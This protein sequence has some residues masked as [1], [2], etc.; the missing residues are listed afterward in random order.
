MA[1][2]SVVG[3]LAEQ[4]REQPLSEPYDKPLCSRVRGYGEVFEIMS[5]ERLR[6]RLLRKRYAPD[7]ILLLAPRRYYLKEII[8]SREVLEGG[9]VDR[10]PW[11][12]NPKPNGSEPHKDGIRLA[13]A[14]FRVLM[15]FEKL[16]RAHMVYVLLR[17]K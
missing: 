7:S 8:G 14:I 12:S 2:L 1:E 4:P 17:D 6:K 16:N 3:T 15:L 13:K 11:A 9:F 10:P 5:V